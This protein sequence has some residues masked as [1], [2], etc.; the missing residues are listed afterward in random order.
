[1]YIF[2]TAPCFIYVGGCLVHIG[3]SRSL[4]VPR[5]K[6][7]VHAMNWRLGVYGCAYCVATGDYLHCMYLYSREVCKEGLIMVN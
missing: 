4:Y 7:L 1:M 5:Q 6:P 2:V 3:V